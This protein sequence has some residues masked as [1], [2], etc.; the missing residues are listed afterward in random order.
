MSGIEKFPDSHN[1][2][3]LTSRLTKM[4]GENDYGYVYLQD[5]IRPQKTK[6]VWRSNIPSLSEFCNYADSA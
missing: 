3:I 5:R 2:L 1:N 4:L 6:T